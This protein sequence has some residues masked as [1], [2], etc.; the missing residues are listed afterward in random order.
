LNPRTHE[1]QLEDQRPRKAQEG[2]LEEGK[3]ARPAKDTK[4]GKPSQNGKQEIKIRVPHKAYKQVFKQLYT[5]LCQDL[6]N[7]SE[8]S[9]RGHYR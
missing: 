9:K 7:K 5:S 6:Q 3:A 4:S 2:H 1:A 8:S